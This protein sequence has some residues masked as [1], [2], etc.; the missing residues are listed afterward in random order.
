MQLKVGCLN[1]SFGERNMAIFVV[2]MATLGGWGRE[3]SYAVA[4]MF[5]NTKVRLVL[6]KNY[7]S[8]RSAEWPSGS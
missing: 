8:E 6:F 2:V 1:R 4:T 7:W 5:L 3:R